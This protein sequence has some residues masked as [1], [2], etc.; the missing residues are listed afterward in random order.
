MGLAFVPFY[1]TYLGP[2]AFGIVGFVALVQAFMGILDLGMTPT[3]TREAARYEAKASDPVHFRD[4]LRSIEIITLFLSVAIF[5]SV[6]MASSLIA[7]YWMQ[8]E[9]LLTDEIAAALSIA[10]AVISFRFFETIY[11]G[12]LYGLQRQVLANIIA[13]VMATFRA[14]GSVVLLAYFSADIEMFFVWQAC[15]SM[16]TILALGACVYSV[17]PKSHRSGRFS[18]AVLSSVWR[19]ASGMLAISLLSLIA[20]QADKVLLSALIPLNDFGFYVFAAK[21]ASIIM[22]ISGPILS[23]V[24]PKLVQHA[25]M[26]DE[27][28]L[29]SKLHRF[30]KIIVCLT[31]PVALILSLFS[32]QVIFVWSG[33]HDLAINVGPLLSLLVLGTFLHAQC[34]LPYQVQLAYGWTSLSVWTNLAGVF[35]VLVSVSVFVPLYGAISAAW[36][37]VILSLLYFLVSTNFTFLRYIKSERLAFYV[38]DVGI[39]SGVALIVAYALKWLLPI[40]EPDRLALL[41]SILFTLGVTFA[42]TAF[43]A[44]VLEGRRAGCVR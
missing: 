2:E 15:L 43:A 13:A 22:I 30:A 38:W 24:Y 6:A 44:F 17:I 40:E 28:E 12:S 37:W 19:F 27:V 10:A 41:L 18:I 25:G 11:R 35:L 34:I 29:I 5:V 1:I 3:L 9:N 26:N 36:T 33:D 4:L 42:V 32:Q 14:G 8:A 16:L 21:V 39:P 31:A 23:A 7:N 20:T